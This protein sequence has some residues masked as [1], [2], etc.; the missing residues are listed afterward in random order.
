M[1]LLVMVLYSQCSTS[2]CT[3]RRVIVWINVSIVSTY[4][5][6]HGV[7]DEDGYFYEGV[8][9]PILTW[10]NRG[11]QCEDRFLQTKLNSRHPQR[12]N[13]T[14][15]LFQTN[16]NSRHSQRDTVTWFQT[17]LKGKM[18]PCSR[19]NQTQ[20]S[21]KGKMLPSSRFIY[22]GNSRVLLG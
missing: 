2:C 4:D 8:N 6:S 17:K 15:T 10:D 21:L 9:T 7:A 5:E 1:F 16:V 11:E 14:V 20:E 18:L 13:V 12:Q 22:I 19:S 3:K